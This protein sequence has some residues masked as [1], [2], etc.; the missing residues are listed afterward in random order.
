MPMVDI[1]QVGTISSIEI[2]RQRVCKPLAGLGVLLIAVLP[3]I[4][5]FQSQK[6]SCRRCVL[7]EREVRVRREE[8]KYARLGHGEV[9]DWT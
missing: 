2:L 5:P 7:I 6:F 9:L 4:Q 3:V 1:I 8:L